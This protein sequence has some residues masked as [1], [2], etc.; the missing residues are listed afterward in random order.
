MGGESSESDTLQDGSSVVV[1]TRYTTEFAGLYAKV[2]QSQQVGKLRAYIDSFQWRKCGAGACTDFAETS[3]TSQETHEM[4]VDTLVSFLRTPTVYVDKREFWVYFKITD[5]AG[6]PIF[7]RNALNSVVL[8]GSSNNGFDQRLGS[9]SCTTG[10]SL[11]SLSS[12][13]N[14][15]MYTCSG[16]ALEAKFSNASEIV[17][18]LTIT[19]SSATDSR[20]YNVG[21]ENTTSAGRNSLMLARAP[22][23]W[24]S[25]LRAGTRQS[26]PSPYSASYD[27]MGFPTTPTHPAVATC[28]TH[29]IYESE[30][31]DVHIYNT[32]T[33]SANLVYGFTIHVKF[34]ASQVEY[35]SVVYDGLFP[36]GDTNEDNLGEGKVTLTSTS[37]QGSLTDSS[38]VSTPNKYVNGF[39]PYAKVRFRRK[40]GSV[41]ASDGKHIDTGIRVN[42]AEVINDG[43]TA[44][45]VADTGTVMQSSEN[46][47]SELFD[48]RTGQQTFGGTPTAG[49]FILAATPQDRFM[50]YNYATA[51]SNKDHGHVFNRRAIDGS[52][53]HDIDFEGF[54]VN[55]Y[56]PYSM[57]TTAIHADFYSSRVLHTCEPDANSS[58][59]NYEAL[60]SAAST[61]CSLRTK[62][63]L[64]N[65]V[66]NSRVRGNAS[67]FSCS[68]QPL[69]VCTGTVE[70]RIVSPENLSIHVDDPLLSR[71]VS[72]EEESGDGCS[73]TNLL[74]SAYQTTRVRVLADGLDVTSWATGMQVENT[75]VANFL[76]APGQT[77]L[78]TR[79]LQDLVRGMVPGNT[80]I[81]LHDQ[82]G[83]ASVQLVVDDA[84]ASITSVVAKV[85]TD[86]E[87]K[88]SAPGAITY[89]SSTTAEVV[90]KQTFTSKPAGTSRGHYGYMF[91]RAHFDD[92]NSE[93]VLH[94]DIATIVSTPNII[95]TPPGAI[96]DHANS[97]DLRMYN[98]NT[99]RH[100]VTLSKTASTECAE[101][102]VQVNFTRCNAVIGTG[103]PKINVVIPGAIGIA[104][105]ISTNLGALDLTPTNDGASFPP[106]R[107]VDTTTTS[108]F[109]LVV[110]F[111]D[112][113]SV[114][115]FAEEPDSDTTS[116]V[117][118]S[119]DESCAT[120]DNDANT[121]TVV[122][123]SNCTEVEIRVSVTLGDATFS[124]S[125]VAPLVRL[126]SL[127]TTAKA[128][129]DGDSVGTS[130]DLL[131]L[132]CGA[133][134]ERYSLQTQGELT[135]G[136]LRSISSSTIVQYASSNASVAT[137]NGHNTVM[138]GNLD[139]IAEFGA[140]AA[141]FAFGWNTASV[142]WNSS[143]V[144]I[145]PFTV[146]VYREYVA[147][148]YNYAGSQWNSLPG[149]AESGSAS[150]PPSASSTLNLVQNGT[151]TTTFSLR[152]T[153][154]GPDKNVSFA[155]SNLASVGD[156]TWF[157]HEDVV[158]Y[159][160]G[161][162]S[163]ISVNSVGTL[164]LLQ[165]YH[166]PTQVRAFICADT[167]ALGAD[168]SPTNHAA[169][170]A[171]QA[172]TNKYLW[173]NLRPGPEDV[174]V[175]TSD[176]M[177]TVT[178]SE[179]LPPFYFPANINNPLEMKLHVVVRP[180]TGT[181][182]RSVELKIVLPEVVGLSSS[183]FVW[184]TNDGISPAYEISSNANFESTESLG[185]GRVN[186]V[187]KIVALHP[188]TIPVQGTVYLG[189][190]VA[191]AGDLTNVPQGL[192][193]DGIIT[194]IVELQSVNEATSK[195][196]LT[197]AF[198]SGD[199]IAGSGSFYVG[200][201]SR[202]RLSRGGWAYLGPLAF[203]PRRVSRRAQSCNPCGNVNDRV[204]GDAN[205][206]CK[207]TVADATYVQKM[208]GTRSAY[209][210]ASN[211]GGSIATDPIHSLTSCN[212]T[213]E[214]FNPLLDTIVP[215]NTQNDYRATVSA[216]HVGVTDVTHIIRACASNAVFIEPSTECV[217]SSSALG[218]RPD[219]SIN[220]RVHGNNAAESTTI[221]TAGLQ[222]H[223]DVLVVGQDAT[224]NPNPAIEFNVTQGTLATQRL[225]DGVA[226]S[227]PLAS[228]YS[229]YSGVSGRSSHSAVLLA[230]YDA[231]GQDWVAQFQPHNY[232]GA[233]EYYVAI[234]SGVV[235]SNGISMP[236]GYAVWLGTKIA[237][238]GDD[239]F[240]P[241]DGMGF[242][243]SYKPVI[244]DQSSV[245]QT[246]ATLCPDV[247]SPPG[248]PPYP[249]NAAPLP[250]PS[251]PPK[252]PPSPP[253]P[254][255]PPPSPPPS[256]PPPSPPPPI[257]PPSPP[258]PS[259]PPAPRPP[260]PSP[261]LEACTLDFLRSKYTVLY[262]D[263]Y[264]NGPD[265]TLVA[266]FR[267]MENFHRL[268][269]DENSYS[270][271]PES[272]ACSVKQFAFLSCLDIAGPGTF[273]GNS[274]S[275]AISWE[276]PASD[277]NYKNLSYIY[278]ESD[279]PTP[280]GRN[281]FGINC[282]GAP[283]A[284]GGILHGDG[285]VN[286]YDIGVLVFAMFQDPPYDQLPSDEDQYYTVETVEQRP[287]TQSRCGDAET[288][289]DWQMQ[290][291]NDSYC[292]ANYLLLTEPCA[293]NADA[294]S[295]AAVS[296]ENGVYYLDG[297]TTPLAVAA[298]VTYYF[299]G[300]PTSHPMKVWRPDGDAEC[301]VQEHACPS[302][303][304]NSA[305]CTGNASWT[306]PAGCDHG[307]FSLDCV[308]H[309]AMGAT[310]RL[311]LG[312]SCAAP[313]ALPPPLAPEIGSGEA[314][315]LGDRRLRRLVDEPEGPG[316]TP[317]ALSDGF[318]RSRFA[319]ENAQGSWH[320]FEFAPNIV[321]MITE[322]FVNGLWVNGNSQL[323][324]APP[325]IDG[326]EVPIAPDKFQVR[327]SRTTQ[328]LDYAR[329]STKYLVALDD[330]EIKCKN[331]VS[332]ATGLQ[333][334]MGDTISVRQEGDGLP[335]PFWLYLWVP[336]LDGWI[337]DYEY[338]LIN[339]GNTTSATSQARSIWPKRGSTAMTTT[340]AVV[341]TRDALEQH[342]SNPPPLPPPPSPPPSPP[343][344]PSPPFPPPQ[345]FS[346]VNATQDFN[347]QNA[348]VDVVVEKLMEVSVVVTNNV[349]AF[350]RNLTNGDRFVVSTKIYGLE[351]SALLA[352]GRAR[353]ALLTAGI[354]RR[355][356][357]EEEDDDEEECVNGARFTVIVRFLDAVS[358]EVI[359]QLRDAWTTIADYTGSDLVA[360][361][362]VSFET[363]ISV[364]EEK[365]TDDSS[366]PWII[367][368]IVLGSVFLI[369]CCFV[370]ALVVLRRRRRE[371]KEKTQKKF[372]RVATSETSSAYAQNAF[373]LRQD[374]PN[375]AHTVQN[376]LC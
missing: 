49:M 241:G 336:R 333:S 47:Y 203:K 31:F 299:T 214:Q 236:D 81:L 88:S 343:S 72:R 244:G 370:A 303:H 237:P 307:A 143:G 168:G 246:S 222:L 102:S 29:P 181:Y 155:F 266:E 201:P 60:S 138:A 71:I 351:Q 9:F 36:A 187:L 137:K 98:Q 46:I 340:G 206:D 113:S 197:P 356:L 120:V 178:Q 61:T 48:A 100:L 324:N 174:D 95:V 247:F 226:H 55:D 1:G 153:R 163:V 109:R 5:F 132:P 159:W 38:G 4:S 142:P 27:T 323:T 254:S 317:S 364:P 318:V 58:S 270:N 78:Y 224:S 251:P 264:E 101:F 70:L 260:P 54:V 75:T 118:T 186:R 110:F 337:S 166:L 357:S 64:N 39:F 164:T 175:G 79:N 40:Q 73:A 298:G 41:L 93:E 374:W 232:S 68:A 339:F 306:I 116:I 371:D 365:D 216:P 276:M 104:F 328:Q 33:Y 258:P 114:D 341:L 56:M 14:T 147:S 294:G 297:A 329:S 253:P 124:G 148:R 362:E 169:S 272:F 84:L 314:P 338:A 267:A 16:S 139:G 369:C 91:V 106:F 218:D 346:G 342:A 327:W 300:I 90:V 372:K 293:S 291:Y 66:S 160:S 263:N 259:P 274:F 313:P 320:G 367:I 205:G 157:S 51:S 103:F 373:K 63:A 355:A 238:F 345:L 15:W 35:D 107:G 134:H 376:F 220:T 252:P 363:E 12:T 358:F 125:D 42:V 80:S 269:I 225:V 316:A 219:V 289:A 34:N 65:D 37:S 273:T 202:R 69:N 344:P 235:G 151:L 194:E 82:P 305:Y 130:A 127:E 286:S 67:G 284:P 96:D 173:A 123:G 115:T 171:E 152:Y 3:L 30:A 22:M 335:C 308:Y 280:T 277:V 28:P 6:S 24:H 250:P 229:G 180:K 212:F 209:A 20:S 165:N 144:T 325:P 283:N 146:T 234:A 43:N 350:L 13:S 285:V 366:S 185:Q 359:Q 52:D 249:P 2:Q 278:L 7:A 145:T 210:D 213:R 215:S 161:T 92:G 26:L 228:T 315:P 195:D 191:S 11:G 121:L 140:T 45:T 275:P 86:V 150:T 83:A 111:E 156:G 361:N 62:I 128:F 89:P 217:A 204:F 108:G 322:L 8:S 282:T 261:P 162:T 19:A 326:S 119:A 176:R 200:E 304:A 167:G 207:L 136:T 375:G 262:Q 248:L 287:E 94:G 256:P 196:A 77:N 172:L 57:R 149:T 257:P 17:G 44:M 154:T 18:D 199:A 74:R 245:V 347:V 239:R 193:S 312:A 25:G 302:R 353:L 310:D 354:E 243:S 99:Q 279:D 211:A 268:A 221:V 198:V 330:T 177:A 368:G 242:K 296:V 290:L 131:S 183:D 281:L 255:P 129:P 85:I 295:A 265:G 97:S 301:A 321:P 271:S 190:W 348:E 184:N 23:W 208:I 192:H 311:V 87:W 170:L 179:Q 126:K 189:H 352:A 188:S 50:M 158:F 227:L 117:Y 59:A 32:A 122:E 233:V 331:I 141:E 21:S 240:N 309:G 182:L 230:D 319:G 112:G 360:C 349:V 288:R 332:G 133:G 231:V 334:I 10:N 53:D 223:Y 105:N 135:T 292:P 76:Q